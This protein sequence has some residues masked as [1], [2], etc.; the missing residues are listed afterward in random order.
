MG[1]TKL[2]HDPQNVKQETKKD[3]N[4]MAD[5]CSR[6]ALEMKGYFVAS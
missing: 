5:R 4:N 6:C 2:F 3:R 1:L